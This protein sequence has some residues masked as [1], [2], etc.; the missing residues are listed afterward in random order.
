MPSLG[1]YS[2]NHWQYSKRKDSSEWLEKLHWAKLKSSD[3]KVKE[4]GHFSTA[5]IK[6]GMAFLIP[7]FQMQIFSVRSL[8]LVSS[9]SQC[10]FRLIS[11]SW[12]TAW[13]HKLLIFT[14]CITHRF[15]KM[16]REANKIIYIFHKINMI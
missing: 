4:Q 10:G 1:S 3:A 13:G 15:S 5:Q 8:K 12:G 2:C 6:E 16:K 7:L 11:K 9:S 14:S